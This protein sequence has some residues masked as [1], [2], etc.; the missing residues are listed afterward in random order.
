VRDTVAAEVARAGATACRWARRAQLR[1]TLE[2]PGAHAC[3]QRAEKY[4]RSIWHLF[5]EACGGLSHFDGRFWTTDLA[6]WSASPA[7]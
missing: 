6:L 2:G 4:D 1:T 5:L 3:G 7:A